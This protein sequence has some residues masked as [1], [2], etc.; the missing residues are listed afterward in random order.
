MGQTSSA[1][2]LPAY[3]EKRDSYQVSHARF[4]EAWRAFALRAATQVEPPGQRE[5]GRV[6]AEIDR[7]RELRPAGH[8]DRLAETGRDQITA[9]GA[10]RADEADR[11][12]AL[13]ARRLQG[14][15]ARR[16][17]LAA[18]PEQV[19]FA[20]D[21]GDHAVGRAVADAGRDKQ[22]QEHRQEADEI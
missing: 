15:R 11:C 20:E 4:G 22:D 18:D 3:G 2:L 17:A 9:D 10:D 21:R 14:D 7:E 6:E 1:R 13:D 16:V 5:A 12:T 8:G 19:L